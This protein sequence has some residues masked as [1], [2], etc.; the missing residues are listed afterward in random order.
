MILED[1]TIHE[2]SQVVGLEEHHV[3]AMRIYTSDSFPFFNNPMRQ[4]VKPHPLMVTIYFLD[5]ALK[6]LTTVEAKLHPAEYNKIKYLWRGMRNMTLDED[7]F[8]QEGGTE[9]V[10]SGACANTHTHTH[11]WMHTPQIRDLM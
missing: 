6:M 7:L 1:F 2:I 11:G 9:L 10:S 4:R 5:Q 3:F 8:F